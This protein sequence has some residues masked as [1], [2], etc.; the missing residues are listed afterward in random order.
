MKKLLNLTF[1]AILCAALLSPA[2]VSASPANC[3]INQTGPGSNNQCTVEEN[4]TCEVN[5]NTGIDIDNDNQQNT[6]S[7]NGSV[8]GNTE[9]GG[10]SSGD[11]GNKNETGVGVGVD[12][13]GCEP[14]KAPGKG[15]GP[16]PVDNGSP[17]KGTEKCTDNDDSDV[18][19]IAGGKG[20]GFTI[21][22]DTAAVSPVALVGMAAL[23]LGGI[24]LASRLGVYAYARFKA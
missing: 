4:T 6:E 19:P 24:A 10:A 8:G 13:G 11:A 3:D 7:G 9:G 2:T 5:N 1:A 12:N 21:L 16:T 15:A 17:V 23:A 14:E 20:G 18:C 22:P